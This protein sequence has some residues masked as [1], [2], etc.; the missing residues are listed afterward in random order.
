MSVYEDVPR[1]LQW[2]EF[3]EGRSSNFSK[4]GWAVWGT[5]VWSKIWNFAQFV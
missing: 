5:N 4:G 3:A 1:I 2:T